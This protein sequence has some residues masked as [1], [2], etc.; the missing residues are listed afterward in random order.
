MKLKIDF[1]TNSSSASFMILKCNLTDIQ[2]DMINDHINIGMIIAE[3]RGMKLWPDE[4]EIDEHK[5]S[6][7]GYTSM[8]NFDMVWFLYAIG[9][10]DEYIEYDSNNG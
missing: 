7:V 5:D 8:D 4:W 9:I 3:N 1:V 10:K 2:I 6:I